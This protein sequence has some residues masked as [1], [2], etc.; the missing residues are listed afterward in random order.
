MIK[1]DIVKTIA[2][3]MNL[4]DRDA[5][6]IVDH[7][8]DAVKTVVTERERLEIRDFGVFQVKQRKPRIGRNPRNK[9]EYPIAP[10]K[11]VTF[12][13]GKNL[14]ARAEGEPAPLPMR[15]IRRKTTKRPPVAEADMLGALGDG[16][17]APARPTPA[18]PAVEEPIVPP[19]AA[20]AVDA[21]HEAPAP[22]AP[23]SN[24]KAAAGARR[25]KGR[26]VDDSDANKSAPA[27]SGGE[28]LTMDA[29]FSVDALAG[30]D[31]KE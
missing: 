21:T 18:R 9:K 3:E 11:V 20:E 8:I 6:G 30:G 2:Q 22:K 13:A 1:A 12:K 27:E 31:G 10:H 24:A 19:L 17:V 15:G 29:F 23:E 26:K 16:A 4:G 14:R 25:G 28:Q 7:I 5:L